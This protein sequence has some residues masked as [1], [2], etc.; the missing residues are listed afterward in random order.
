MI[1]EIWSLGCKPYSTLTD[2]EQVC[3]YCID[4]WMHTLEAQF[5]VI[6]QNSNTCFFLGAAQVGE[7][8][9]AV[10]TSWFSS[11]NLQTNG[12]FLVRISVCVYHKIP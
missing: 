5:V 1:W 9:Q 10:S 3:L 7:R 12:R 11:F 8:F 2:V 4:G 6:R